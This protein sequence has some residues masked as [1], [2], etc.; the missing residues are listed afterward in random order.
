MEE[1]NSS[2]HTK[3][4]YIYDANI[5]TIP[6]GESFAHIVLGHIKRFHFQSMVYTT[7][8]LFLVSIFDLAK[9]LCLKLCSVPIMCAI[10]APSCTQNRFLQACS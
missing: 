5:H 9:I 6:I 10:K 3:Q 2:Q 4:T 8:C 7:G 1:S